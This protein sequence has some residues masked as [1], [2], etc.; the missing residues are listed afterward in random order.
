MLY[1]QAVQSGVSALQLAVTGS[2]AQTKEA[3]N[4]AYKAE[5]SR[6]NI[7]KNR[8][9]SQLNIAAIEQDKVM[10]NTLIKMKQNQA[11]AMAKVSAAAAGVEGGSVDDVIN[12]T[13]TNSVFAIAAS[14]RR[15]EQDKDTQL[16][17]IGNMSSALLSVD[18]PEFSVLGNLLQAFSSVNEKDFKTGEAL[19]SLWSS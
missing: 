5:A 11:E 17:N 9:T 14:N 13:E 16:A 12:D 1:Q 10:S 3:Y 8:H 15:A 19:S 7:A 2:N 18:E 4:A 6:L